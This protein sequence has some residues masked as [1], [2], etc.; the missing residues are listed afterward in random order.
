[1]V[2][3]VVNF[4]LIANFV[5]S[6]KLRI[7]ANMKISYVVIIFCRS[8]LDILKDQTS[9]VELIIAHLYKAQEDT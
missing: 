8:R 7:G 6:H 5:L 3:S 2:K 9:G 1:V 4:I